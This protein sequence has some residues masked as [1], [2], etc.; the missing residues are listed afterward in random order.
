M[1][2]SSISIDR[3]VLATVMSIVIVLFG[4][5]GY[6]FLGVRE[7]PSVDPPVITVRTSYTGAN[8]DIIESQITEPLEKGINGIS[9]IRTISSSSSVGVSSITVE[10][11]LDADLETAANDVRDK[12]SQAIRSLP[13]DIDAPPVVTKEDANS[14]AIITLSLQSN[15][16]DELE[17]SDYAE[18]VLLE[19]LQTIPGVSSVQ[20]WGQKRY[21]MRMW[22]D[23][24]KLASYQLSPQDVLLALNK[25][26]VELP[27]G[28]IAGASTELT[29]RTLGNLTTESD[30]NNLI[31]KNTGSSII[32]FS[33][34]V[35]CNLLLCS[36]PFFRIAQSYPEKSR[37]NAGRTSA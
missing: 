33:G 2:I 15:K 11:N 14:D 23:P 29:V 9:G 6:S 12:V 27:S 26:N 7:Y 13:L 8:A 37:I 4:A 3:P 16:R 36:F 34:K 25:E 31:I 21:A 19:R 32:R 5:I 1:N 18:N 30:F 24:F 28:K 22:M 17:V 20:I 10:F 35:V